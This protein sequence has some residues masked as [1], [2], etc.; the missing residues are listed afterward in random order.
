VVAL[1]YVDDMSIEQVAR[2]LDI[3]VGT[4][5][6]TLFKARQTLS[7]SLQDEEVTR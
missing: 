6:A 4:V 1:H 2:V 7:K 3:A 5:K